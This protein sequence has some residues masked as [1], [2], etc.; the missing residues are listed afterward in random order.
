MRPDSHRLMTYN[1]ESKVEAIVNPEIMYNSIQKKKTRVI[2]HKVG[3]TNSPAQNSLI[4]FK[5][6]HSKHYSIDR[7]N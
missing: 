7:S 5:V 4:S 1:E 3:K 2:K 6:K